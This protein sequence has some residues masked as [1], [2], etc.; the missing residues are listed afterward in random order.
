MSAPAPRSARWASLCGA[1]AALAACSTAQWGVEDPQGRLYPASSER[2][3]QVIEQFD[4]VYSAEVDSVEPLATPL[5]AS[6][7]VFLPSRESTA[8]FADA[9]TS[10]RVPGLIKQYAAESAYRYFVHHGR[11]VQRRRVFER[12]S[13]VEYDTVERS[14]EGIAMPPPPTDADHVVFLSWS[15]VGD[16]GFLSA[17]ELVLLLVQVTIRDSP[18]YLGGCL[19][20]AAVPEDRPRVS[21]EWLVGLEAM[22]SQRALRPTDG[23]P[24]APLWLRMKRC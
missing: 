15:T 4:A 5:A 23:D 8:R 18:G 21:R 12:A 17:P 11:M 24:E 16:S 14:G 2:V 20:H 7:A 1:V 6:A 9:A 3:D 22:I 13:V 19:L 10:M